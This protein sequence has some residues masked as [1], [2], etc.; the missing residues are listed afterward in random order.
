MPTDYLVVFAQVHEDFR[1]PELLS[2]SEL[3]EFTIHFSK[4]VQDLDTSRPFMMFGL[5][6]EEHARI[7]AKRC[8]LIKSAVTFS[9]GDSSDISAFRSICEFYAT[10]LN[11]EDLH[12]RVRANRQQWSRFIQ[13]TSFKFTVT[14]YNHT[15]PQKRQRQ[16]IESFS[17]LGFLGKIDMKSPELIMACY[18]ECESFSWYTKSD[19]NRMFSWLEIQASEEHRVK[20]PRMMET[21]CKCISAG[22]CV[23]LY[24]L[25]SGSRT[26]YFVVHQ[27]VEGSARPLIQKF[28]IKKRSYY[29]NTSMDAEISLIMANQS[30]VRVKLDISLEN[31]IFELLRHRQENWCMT[32]LWVQ[33][34]WLMFAYFLRFS[35]P[36][37]VD[38]ELNRRLRISG[39]SFLD[40]TLLVVKSEAKVRFSLLWGSYTY[41]NSL[42]KRRE[43]RHN[44]RSKSVWC[45]FENYRSLHVR[46]HSKSLAMRRNIR[47][48]RNRP[49]M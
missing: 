24:V 13:D 44:W 34:V 18:E 40:L 10:G 37:I 35:A 39:H 29:G 47:R 27:I 5:D 7:L 42:S 6:D 36:D 45:C 1:I 30:L 19:F 32:L 20:N 16:T 9:R 12:E 4:P 49:P 41:L 26:A 14:G 15:I 48:H 33:E 28:D 23:F 38:M 8:I 43:S 46:C 31:S 2:I 3:H 25:V 21:F 11:Y 22:W 17:Y